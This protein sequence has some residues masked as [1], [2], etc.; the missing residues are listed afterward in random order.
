M[1]E[2]EFTI[3]ATTGELTM[4]VRGSRVPV[5]PTSP[6]W[7]ANSWASRSKS[8]RRRSTTCGRRFVHRFAASADSERTDL[9]PRPSDGSAGDRR[10]EAQEAPALVGDLLPPA[11]AVNC[12]RR[13]SSLPLSPEVDTGG[14]TLRVARLYHGS[15]VDGPGR[16]SV[17]QFQGCPIRCR[18]FIYSVIVSINFS[19]V[20]T[21]GYLVSSNQERAGSGGGPMLG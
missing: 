19:E 20:N 13:L 6:G 12:V 9:D 8:G 21:S 10:I 15:V 17:V 11:Q 1:A 14:P 2:I 18:G 3:D 7:Q 4:H 5:V 16:R